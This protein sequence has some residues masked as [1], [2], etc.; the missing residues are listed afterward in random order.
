[1]TQAPGLPFLRRGGKPPAPGEAR[2]SLP[3]AWTSASAQPI[4]IVAPD[5]RCGTLLLECAA[6]M[7]LAEIVSGPALIVRLQPPVGGGWVLELLALL[8]RWLE[9]CRLPCAKLLYG[10]RSYVIRASA[11]VAQFE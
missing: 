8:E 5:R 10:G 4:E 6:P 1:M 2:P 7:F 11:E 3:S 9:S